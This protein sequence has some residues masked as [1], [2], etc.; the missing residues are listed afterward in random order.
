MADPDRAWSEFD[1]AYDLPGVTGPVRTYVVAT[2]QR[3]GSHYF[4]DLV[5]RLGTIGV[6][7]EYLNGHRMLV[8]LQARG[9]PVTPEEEIR[10]FREAQRR[11]TGSSGWF[12]LKTHWHTWEAV[13]A[14]RGLRDLVRPQ[15]FLYLYRE[16]RVAQAASLSLAEQT[17][18]W[19]NV[20]Q[21]PR[22]DPVYSRRHIDDASAR[23]HRETA[24][25][26]RF[27]AG[28]EEDVLRLSYESATADPLQAL[29]ATCRHLGVAPPQAGQVGPPRIHARDNDLVE[30]WARRYR[31]EP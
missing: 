14:K 15:R 2:T 5:G 19:V 17:G 30:Q 22:A 25:W 29:A 28:R 27:F 16:D 20:S 24:A 4:A 26:E 11:R 3:T 13:Q 9:R 21:A 23:L 8:E 7:F 12:G 31:Q 1:A 6:P 10:L 18:V